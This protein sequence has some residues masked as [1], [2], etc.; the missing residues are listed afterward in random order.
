MG[1]KKEKNALETRHL[2]L[3]PMESTKFNMQLYLENA[4]RWS[5]LREENII[6]D[7]NT[8]TGQSQVD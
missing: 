1:F 6:N 5:S 4:T 2:Q 7:P 3:Q 8:L